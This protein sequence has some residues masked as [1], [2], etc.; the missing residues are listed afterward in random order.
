M[1]VVVVICGDARDASH[2]GHVVRRRGSESRQSSS[3]T[4]DATPASGVAE[5][6][7]ST[8]RMMMMMVAAR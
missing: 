5:L 3:P 2:N 6:V 4:R 1:A 7:S 8:M